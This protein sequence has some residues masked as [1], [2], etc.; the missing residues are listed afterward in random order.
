M[1]FLNEH[2]VLPLSDL[3]TGQSVHRYLQFL[4]KSSSW[5][6]DK[7][8]EFQNCL[9]EKLIRN[10]ISHVPFYRTLYS[11]GELPICE[12]YSIEDIQSFPIVDKNK[13]R[14]EGLDLFSAD[15]IRYNKKILC[16]SSGT[17]GEPFAF[18]VSKQA[19]SVNTAAKIRNWYEAGY[20]LGD[21][22]MKIA[23]APRG[24]II[25]RVQDNL[26]NCTHV[27]FQSLDSGV[28]QSILFTIDK[29]KPS[30]I[31]THPNV[32]FYLAI[33]RNAG[34]YCH[35][36]DI[37]MTTSSN[38]T[39]TYREIIQNA[40]RCDVIDSYSCE[41]TASIAENKLHDGYHISQEYGFIEVLDDNNKPVKNG[42]GHVV[43]TD[44]WNFATPFIRYN[45]HDRVEMRDGVIIRIIGRENEMF[46]AANGNRYTGQ[47]ICDYF[48]YEAK[49]VL[50]YQF[51]VKK[52]GQLL[53]RIVPDSS[54]DND[55]QVKMISDWEQRTGQPVCIQIVKYIPVGRNGKS[56]TVISE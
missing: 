24:S 9:L 16:H 13:M 23:S 29:T 8:R 34:S 14:C 37:I 17:T 44:L 35:F 53:I 38:L 50:A 7:M 33:E 51:V 20:R 19:Y 40:F 36:P 18:Y 2:I 28:L 42:Y 15:N 12:S 39:D 43:S 4:L 48:S 5:S 54:F 22:Y 3:I 47:I 11:R 46:E 30:V 55:Q 52:N 56:L 25:K 26:N 32:A 1:S 10:T 45:T 27:P 21:P 6:S 41:G 31:R 49:G